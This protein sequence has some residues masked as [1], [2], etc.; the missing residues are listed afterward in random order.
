VWVERIH[1]YSSAVGGAVPILL[2]AALVGA[3]SGRTLLEEG[4]AQYEARDFSSAL[5]SLT[6]ALDAKNGRRTR[7]RI[8]VYIGL[9][10]VEYEL[11]KDAR[12]SFA[13]ALEHDPRVRVPRSAPKK[14][15]ALFAK[16][17]KQELGDKARPRRQRARRKVEPASPPPTTVAPPPP[18]T[19][20]PPPP[21]PPPPRVSPPP[22][23]A[24]PPPA[25]TP[26]PEA[27]VEVEAPGPNVPG[28]VLASLGG[29]ALVT[30]AVLGGV[31]AST[32]RR[33][34]EEVVAARAQDLYQDAVTQRTVA[35]VSLGV[36]AVAGG[37]AAYFF[38]A[39]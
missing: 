21:A 34:D 4:I 20:A 35:F 31:S 17:R 26:D 13:E 19:R 22:P 29:A 32:A 18:P 8:H 14:A 2:C 12:S 39:E 7:A 38:A 24:P 15:R 23:A 37:L 1:V 33:A 9:I 27:A 6:S 25:L 36:G 30:G 3:P 10:Q 16:V 5:A 28:W 11:T